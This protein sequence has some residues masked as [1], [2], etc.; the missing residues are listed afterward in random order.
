MSD[1]WTLSEP[2]LIDGICQKKKKQK[3]SGDRLIHGGLH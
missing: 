3:S 2:Q 1:L